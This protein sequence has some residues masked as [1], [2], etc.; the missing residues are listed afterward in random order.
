M[1][2]L[3]DPTDSTAFLAQGVALDNLRKYIGH[4][5]R[6]HTAEQN[7]S[8]VRLQQRLFTK[9]CISVSNKTKTACH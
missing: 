5:V 8:C 1:I 4:A 7:M 6:A 3:H 9:V 2:E